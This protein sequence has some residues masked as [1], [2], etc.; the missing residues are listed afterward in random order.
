MISIIT[1][2]RIVICFQCRHESTVKRFGA[3]VGL[4]GGREKEQN[5]CVPNWVWRDHES[6]IFNTWRP[7]HNEVQSLT[8]VKWFR[9]ERVAVNPLHTIVLGVAKHWT[10]VKCEVALALSWVFQIQCLKQCIY[11]QNNHNND[12]NLKNSKNNKKNMSS[13]FMSE[14]IALNETRAQVS[15]THRG[16]LDR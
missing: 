11:L 13:I 7:N 8:A 1:I 12:N 5:P 10:V 14:F 9:R 15:L 2:I 4:C 3:C 6:T 16:M